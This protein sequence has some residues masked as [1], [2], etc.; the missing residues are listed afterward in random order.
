MLGGLNVN[1]LKNNFNSNFMLN[2]FCITLNRI[3]DEFST[4]VTDNS[5]TL[6]YHSVSIIIGNNFRLFTDDLRI[7]GH[8]ALIVDMQCIAMIIL[9]FP[10][11]LQLGKLDF[12]YR[13]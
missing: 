6:L 8:G 7:S 4:R 9:G 12:L 5:V 2:C 11:K 13:S 1:L 3:T 10:N